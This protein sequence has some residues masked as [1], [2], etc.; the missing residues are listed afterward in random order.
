M[1]DVEPHYLELTQ[2]AHLIQIRKLSPVELTQAMLA[3]IE[4][5]DRKLHS[6]ALVTPELALEQARKAEKEIMGRIYRG[7][8]HG[9]P[10]GLKDLCYTKGIPTAAGMPI[11]RDFKPTYDGTVVKRLYDA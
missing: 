11:H 10:I 3:R 9:V 4:S 6:Y 7:A 5:L 8:L 1:N 2:I